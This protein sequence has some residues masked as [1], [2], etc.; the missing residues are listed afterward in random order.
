VIWA[1]ARA[2]V[3]DRPA[4]ALAVLG[5]VNEVIDLHTVRLAA[6]RKHLPLPVV[7]L[8]VACS[9]LA[10][11]VIG[12]GNGLGGERS[13]TLTVP[14]VILISSAL[15]ITI[16]LDHPRA[17]LIQLSDAPLAALKLGAPAASAS[18]TPR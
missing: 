9:L 1:A 13:A 15:W 18:P 4:V 11:G 3:A 7:G 16:D 6:G 14:L 17:G 2:G 5:P 10:I 12:Y 8:L